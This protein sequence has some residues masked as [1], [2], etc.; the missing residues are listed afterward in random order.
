MNLMQHRMLKAAMYV[1]YGSS[2][3]VYAKAA[4]VHPSLINYHFES[5][6]KFLDE[7]VRY[8]VDNREPRVIVGAYLSG[9]KRGVAISADML[10]EMLDKLKR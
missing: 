4:E 5:M 10:N 8:A 2:R 3:A 7:V 1:P 9:D 6:D